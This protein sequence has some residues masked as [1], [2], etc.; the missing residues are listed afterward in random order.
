MK[1]RLKL[2]GKFNVTCYD[3]EG[4]LKWM[5]VADNIVVNEGLQKILDVTFD[6]S[7]AKIS[8]WYIGLGDSNIGSAGA[9]DTAA[10]HGN[11]NET[12]GYSE[13]VRQV[14]TDART[15]QSV[16]NTASAASFSMNATDNV[17][18]AFLSSDSNKATTAG[19][20]LCAAAFAEGTK[21]VD[22]GDTVNVEYTFTAQDVAT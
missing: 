9:T 18:G 1:T 11:F 10:G 5:D 17:G 3:K 20:L 8:A 19:V 2:G 7:V 14:F 16:S 6:S 13:S 12:T 4:N 21:A 15:N 22:N